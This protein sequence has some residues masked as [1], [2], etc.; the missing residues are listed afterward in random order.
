MIR[1]TNLLLVVLIVLALTFMS[2][3]VEN[4]HLKDKLEEMYSDY[5]MYL[6]H[7]T[8][9]FSPEL[10]VPVDQRLLQQRTKCF[11]CERDIIQRAGMDPRY[12]RLASPTKCFSCEMQFI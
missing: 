3:L 12:L 11:S 4:F 5:G 6:A 9:L 7:P 2:S 8:K 10:D 1:L